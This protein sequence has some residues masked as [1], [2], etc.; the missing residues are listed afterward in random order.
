M[1]GHGFQL[2]HLGLTR[3]EML[4][5]VGMGFGMIGFAGLTDGA[6]PKFGANPLRPRRP[7]FPVKAK[8]VIHIFLNGGPSQVDTFDPKPA[9]D[10]WHG[11]ELP[12]RMITERPTGTCLRSPFKFQ[13]RTERARCE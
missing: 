2:E 1:T 3:R 10:E 6:T 7:Q 11:K 12:K 9:L 8:R 5:R 4:Q 13:K